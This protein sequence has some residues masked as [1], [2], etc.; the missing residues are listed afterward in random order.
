MSTQVPRPAYAV[1]R[2]DDTAAPTAGARSTADSTAAR[3][4]R[5]PTSSRVPERSAGV[6][7]AAANRRRAGLHD[8]EVRSG[9]LVTVFRKCSRVR[10]WRDVD[11]GGDRP[12]DRFRAPGG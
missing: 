5:A 10:L 4:R 8:E 12:G 6:R 2:R 1:G 9:Q 11:D 3:K 7:G